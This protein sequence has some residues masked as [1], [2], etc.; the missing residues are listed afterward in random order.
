[1]TGMFATAVR[2]PLDAENIQ[3]EIMNAQNIII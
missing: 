2:A 3:K 1:M